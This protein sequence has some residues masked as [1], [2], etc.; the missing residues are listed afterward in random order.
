MNTELN[1]FLSTPALLDV[2]DKQVKS[3]IT[4]DRGLPKFGLNTHPGIEAIALSN[5]ASDARFSRTGLDMTFALSAHKGGSIKATHSIG[6]IWSMHYPIKVRFVHT[7]SNS[8][9]KLALAP[10]YAG[11]KHGIVDR[12]ALSAL[13]AVSASFANKTCAETLPS[14]SRAAI[15]RLLDIPVDATRLMY[16]MATM[17]TAAAAAEAQGGA[18]RLANLTDDQ[19][20]RIITSFADYATAIEA[21]SKKG[22]QPVYLGL[23]SSLEPTIYARIARILT[24]TSPK[25]TTAD[26]EAP[27][28][29]C[30]IWPEI[31]GARAYLMGATD[32]V[33]PLSGELSTRDIS[34]FIQYYCAL[35]GCADAFN[36]ILQVVRSFALRPAGSGAMGSSLNLVLALPLPRMQPM[37]LAPLLQPH[38]IFD[39]ETP[40]DYLIQTRQELIRA[41]ARAAIFLSG[42]HLATQQAGGFW[43]EQPAQAAHPALNNNYSRFIKMQTA[44]SAATNATLHLTTELGWEAS[45]TSSWLAVGSTGRPLACLHPIEF[46]EC[47]PFSEALPATAA[48]LAILKPVALDHAVPIYQLSRAAAVNGRLALNDAYYSLLML[49][50]PARLVSIVTNRLTR[51]QSDQTIQPRISYRGLPSDG[52][53][54]SLAT[55]AQSIQMGYELLDVSS[56]LES[57]MNRDQFDGV[58]LVYEWNLP[59]SSVDVYAQFIEDAYVPPHAEE[60]RIVDLQPM[61]TVPIIPSPKDITQPAAAKDI[62]QIRDI[63]GADFGGIVDAYNTM[64][65]LAG[66]Q[67]PTATYEANL[68]TLTGLLTSFVPSMIEFMTD[69]QEAI[70]TS[71]TWF[72]AVC[73]DAREWEYRPSSIDQLQQQQALTQSTLISLMD[74]LNKPLAPPPPPTIEQIHAAETLEPFTQ[75]RISWDEEMEGVRMAAVGTPTPASPIQQAHPEIQTQP[76]AK[77]PPSPTPVPAARPATQS[78]FHPSPPVQQQPPAP[79]V[80]PT[81]ATDPM[82]VNTSFTA[83]R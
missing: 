9:L 10:A 24:L 80:E 3:T 13:A 74:T 31:H 50:K 1:T 8:E 71:L 63:L 7:S 55:E 30:A 25:F 44:G 37:V 53:F 16:R 81:G 52:Q 57:R 18:L 19:T 28:S 48:L 21:V 64:R 65:S 36:S 33:A 47:L 82:P 75:Q 73:E 43:L 27:P 69:D 83:A 39:D 61:T 72:A 45:F 2:P 41:S 58:K 77:L 38:G 26:L 4:N 67:L 6:R 78:S 76:T 34:L 62:T 56:A 68:R 46:E 29:V 79:V 40:D 59:H 70:R 60:T 22:E 15:S 42:Y 49:K 12:A 23:G 14:D 54:F 35:Y 11:F 17:H 66:K 5:I 32:T 20:P 51:T